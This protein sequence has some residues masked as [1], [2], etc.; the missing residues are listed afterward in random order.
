MRGERYRDLARRRGIEAIRWLARHC[1]GPR[2][3]WVWL[4]TRCQPI[5]CLP[6]GC[7]R[8]DTSKHLQWGRR[9]NCRSQRR[10]ISNRNRTK[11]K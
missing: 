5:I 1:L 8:V 4:T 6:A 2:L 10:G 3:M 7:S 9:C 11:D